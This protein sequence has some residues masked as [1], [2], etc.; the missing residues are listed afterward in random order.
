MMQPLAVVYA[1]GYLHVG[2]DQLHAILSLKNDR[3]PNI[4]VT[5]DLLTTGVDVP[6]I[7]NL[8]F[9]RRVNSRILY[10]QMLGRATRRCDDIAKERFRIYDAVDIYKQ[11]EKVNSMK[12]VVTNVDI[13]FSKLESEIKEGKDSCNSCCLLSTLEAAAVLYS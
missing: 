4:V 8:V 13:T 2:W 10:E 11:L 12:P 3:L 6:S 9:M 5:V 1:Q 7:C